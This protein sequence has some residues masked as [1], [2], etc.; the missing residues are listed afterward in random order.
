MNKADP[1]LELVYA[2]TALTNDFMD[3]NRLVPKNDNKTASAID[4]LVDRISSIEYNL[5][6][7]VSN[8]FAFAE[9]LSKQE[10]SDFDKRL[11][12]AV[13]HRTTDYPMIVVLPYPKRFNR[14]TTPPAIIV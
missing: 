7:L 3:K 8:E 1:F 10:L 4:C 14:M 9:A 6:A 11:E 13:L 5:E 2:D 12:E